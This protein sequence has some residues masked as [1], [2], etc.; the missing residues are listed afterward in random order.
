[1]SFG[2]L[3]MRSKANSLISFLF[4]FVSVEV[5]KVVNVDHVFF[6]V[7]H[8]YRLK[9][10]VRESAGELFGYVFLG[11]F[12]L[13]DE[14]RFVLKH[15]F[16][17]RELVFKQVYFIHFCVGC[18]KRKGSR[19]TNQRGAAPNLQALFLNCG[20]LEALFASRNRRSH[21]FWGIYQIP[22]SILGICA[23]PEFGTDKL[24]SYVVTR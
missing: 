24:L 4:I 19:L 1:M 14:N 23:R 10:N 12:T 22:K 8:G 21:S 13:C 6:E 9:V 3:V 20:E 5:G 2:M 18:R 15:T 11:F 7:R 17:V 16:C